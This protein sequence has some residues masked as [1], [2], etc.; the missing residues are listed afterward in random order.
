MGSVEVF[1]ASEPVWYI[2][3]DHG[4]LAGSVES[5]VRVTVVITIFCLPVGVLC[6]QRVTSGCCW[7]TLR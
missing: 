6:S 1:R 4:T 2:E 7:Q 5:G 3:R